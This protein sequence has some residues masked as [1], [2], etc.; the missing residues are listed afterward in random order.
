MSQH[1]VGQLLSG[2]TVWEKLDFVIDDLEQG[3]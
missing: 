3:F 2:L 1:N